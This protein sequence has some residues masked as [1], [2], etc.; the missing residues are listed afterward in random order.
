[1]GVT[2]VPLVDVSAP[3]SLKGVLGT[4]FARVRARARENQLLR[5][6]VRRLRSGWPVSGRRSAEASAG[7][8][9]AGPA[10]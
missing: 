1:M 10:D 2:S 5:T 7:P 4:A 8:G 9:A 6:A 3:A